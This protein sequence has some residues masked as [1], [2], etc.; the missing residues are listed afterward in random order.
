MGA[1][2]QMSK[3]LR[4]V[5]CCLVPTILLAADYPGSLSAG[6]LYKNCR[7]VVGGASTVACLSYIRGALEMRKHVAMTTKGQVSTQYCIPD[8]S[9]EQRRKVFMDWMKTHPQAAKTKASNV[10]VDAFDNAYPCNASGA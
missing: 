1:S 10:I 6:T 9:P 3:S 5:L 8:L 4:V 2:V 7:I